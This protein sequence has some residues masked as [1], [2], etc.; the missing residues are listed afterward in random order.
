MSL[1]PIHEVTEHRSVQRLVVNQAPAVLVHQTASAPHR[2][3]AGRRDAS[4][5]L[6]SRGVPLHSNT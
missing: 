6:L 4:F 3:H 1:A 5:E 2:I